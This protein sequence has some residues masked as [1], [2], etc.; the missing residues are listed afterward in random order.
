MIRHFLTRA[1]LISTIVFGILACDSAVI[2]GEGTS[3][4]GA[5][6]IG[7]ALAC[8]N[9]QPLSAVSAYSY[10]AEDGI[11]TADNAID[12]DFSSE[13]RWSSKGQGNSLVVDLGSAK[14]VGAVNVSWYKSDERSTNFAVETSLDGKKWYSVLAPLSTTE[15]QNFSVENS[16]ARYVKIVGYGNS[17]SDWNSLVE[18]QVLGCDIEQLAGTDSVNPEPASNSNCIAS[19]RLKIN[20][21]K[22]DYEYAEDYTA[23]R[24]I[25]GDLNK[26][27]RWSSEGIGNS[28]TLDLGISSTI[29]RLETAW[30]KGDVRTAFFDVEVSLDNSAWTTSLSDASVSGTEG[31]VSFDIDTANA[32]YVKLIGKGNSDNDWNSLIE[33]DVFGCGNEEAENAAQQPDRPSKATTYAISAV[34]AS[35][36]QASNIP[37]NAIDKLTDEDSRWSAEGRDY[38][39]LELDLG[40]P[41][42][43]NTLDIFFLHNEERNTCFNIQTSMN[44]HD[45]TTQRSNIVS[46]GDRVF[47]FPETNARYVRYAGLGNSTNEWNSIIEIEPMWLPVSGDEVTSDGKGGECPDYVSDNADEIKESPISESTGTFINQG[48][49]DPTKLP[50]ENFDLTYWKIT[51]PDASEAYPPKVVLNE[52][53][54]D[55]KTG[56]MV[57]ECVNRGE[58]TSSSTKYAR[59][60]LREMLRGKNTSI[61][62]KSLGNNWVIS[63]AKSSIRQEAGGIDGNMKST[64]AVDAVSTTYSGGNDFMLGRVIVGQIHGSEDEPF[65][66][67]YRKLPGNSKGSVYFSYEDSKVEKFF[68][69]FGNRDTDASNPSDGIA[70]GEKWSYEVDVRGRDMV[71]TVTKEDGTSK[72]KAITWSSEYDNDWF[73]FKAGNYNQNNGGATGDYAQVSIFALEV[74]HD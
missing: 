40:T 48:S 4:P 9:Q 71:V 59:S 21:A 16:S 46:N 73:Y 47:S 74:S 2:V 53:Y 55:K 72:S 60:E 24:V 51:Y 33:V 29:N 45:W 22:S 27:S 70:L 63:T 31:L 67:F 8:N 25:D 5:P 41:R 35:H 68:E 11:Y 14:N 1:A 54:T 13:S 42:V 10:G 58:Q 43:V 3:G 39:W 12:G 26:D 38:A 57:F 50:T 69:F 37:K 17:K 20:S 19:N 36:Y 61:G 52:F 28:I 62:T 23:E 65:K 34:D 18:L 56:A 66:I 7:Q 64:V 30:Y 44:G 32:R 15:K 49:I 6:P